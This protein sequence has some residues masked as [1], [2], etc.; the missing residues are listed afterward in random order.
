M[1]VLAFLPLL[2]STTNPTTSRKSRTMSTEE[3]MT[4]A[5]KRAAARKAKI[6]ARG[7]AGLNKLAQTARGDEAE[8]LYGN[9]CEQSHTSSLVGDAAG[10]GA[11]SIL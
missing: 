8:K 5:Q 7:N 6:L 3:P 1:H 2:F 4:D 9:D 10:H 11:P